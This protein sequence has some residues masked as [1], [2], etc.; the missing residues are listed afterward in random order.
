[1]AGR[2]G[3]VQANLPDFCKNEQKR[4]LE[5]DVLSEKAD[6]GS[7]GKDEPGGGPCKNEL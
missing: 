4:E 2:L 3:L 1:M 5:H 6:S 7:Y